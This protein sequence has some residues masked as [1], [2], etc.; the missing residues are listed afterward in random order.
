VFRKEITDPA[1][2]FFHSMEINA[3]RRAGLE[4][5]G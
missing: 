5:K 1:V 3:D 2:H 4:H